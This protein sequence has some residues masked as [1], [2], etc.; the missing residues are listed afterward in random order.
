MSDE[1]NIIKEERKFIKKIN[2]DKAKN[3]TILSILLMSANI[4]T[5]VVPLMYKIF[6]FGI[7]FELT[8]LIFLII[9][10]IYMQKYDEVNAKRYIIYSIITI[11]SI[12]LYDLLFL[13]I[14]NFEDIITFMY[15]YF[16]G[17]A[18]S[19]IYVVT[20]V[21]IIKDLSKA[22][23]TIKYKKN[24]DWFYEKYKEENNGGK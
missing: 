24:T 11:E 18:L 3:I 4:L 9:A 16:F 20:L 7:I 14:Q 17:E 5:Y 23:N 13:L 22:N 12:L 10:R 19:I 8:S 21:I 15:N 6:D 1:E 2:I